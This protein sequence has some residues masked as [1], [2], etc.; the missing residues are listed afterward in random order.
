MNKVPSENS[1]PVAGL[2]YYFMFWCSV[3]VCSQTGVKEIGFSPLPSKEGEHCRPGCP[4][5]S[6]EIFLDFLKGWAILSR[7]TQR[8]M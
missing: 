8:Q 3:V 6:L 4:T 1:E 2:S 7:R 5:K